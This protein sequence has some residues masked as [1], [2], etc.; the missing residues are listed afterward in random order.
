MTIR[1]HGTPDEVGQA[2]QRLHDVFTVVDT[3]RLYRDRSGDLVRLYVH[4]RL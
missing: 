3:S 4:V 2:A 1:L